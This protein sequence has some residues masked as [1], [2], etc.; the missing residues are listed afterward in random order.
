M[1]AASHESAAEEGTEPHTLF[2]A[3]DLARGLE[4][5]AHEERW[6]VQLLHDGTVPGVV[7]AGRPV[8][9]ALLDYRERERRFERPVAEFARILPLPREAGRNGDGHGQN[10]VPG[11]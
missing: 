1:I 9:I 3:H 2:Y 4:V 6:H 8:E 7:R 11:Q 10:L 5:R